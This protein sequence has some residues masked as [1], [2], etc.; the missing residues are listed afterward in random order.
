M[1]E[2]D[3]PLLFDQRELTRR[4]ISA[5][6]LPSDAV[7]WNPDPSLWD[8]YKWWIVG[9]GAF[10]LLQTALIAALARSMLRRRR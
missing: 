2:G 3:S 4:G 8:R 10:L 6:R 5:A 7:I 1:K 9:A